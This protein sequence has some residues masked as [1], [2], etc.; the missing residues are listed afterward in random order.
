MLS[1]SAVLFD[2]DGVLVDSTP[3]VERVWRGWATEQGLDP[4]F[5]VQWSHGRRSIETIRRVAPALD[6]P[7]ENQKVERRE[8]EDL[9]GVRAIEGAAELLAAMP[10][11]HW[12][13]VTSATRELAEARMRY[14]SLPLPKDAI[15]AELVARGKPHPEPY[16]KGAALLGFPPSECLVIEDTAA[17]I[18]AAK[19]AGMQVIGLTTTYPSHDLREADVIVRTCADIHVEVRAGA[20]DSLKLQFYFEYSPAEI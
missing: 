8:I 12:T 5:V 1:C 11:G 14:V 6:A 15:T 17:G 2:L 4:D 16:L 3:A 9:E 7:T 13:V 20:E 19:T 10:P 18:A